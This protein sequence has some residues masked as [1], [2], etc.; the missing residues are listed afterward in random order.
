LLLKKGQE[1]GPIVLI[2]CDEELPWVIKEQVQLEASI[3]SVYTGSL[4][5]L[6]NQACIDAGQK[7]QHS[8]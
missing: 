2:W 1:R 5:N 7:I 3:T 6:L 8:M 4:F